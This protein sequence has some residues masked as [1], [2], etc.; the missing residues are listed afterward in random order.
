L[1]S[2]RNL[3]TIWHLDTMYICHVIKISIFRL[4]LQFMVW[5]SNHGMN[6]YLETG[7]KFDLSA[8]S[9]LNLF[10]KFCLKFIF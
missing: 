1:K 6:S 4:N 8:H 10:S 5:K 7:N 9:M 2:S 3:I